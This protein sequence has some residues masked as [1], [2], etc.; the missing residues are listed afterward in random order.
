MRHSK[1]TCAS[2]MLTSCAYILGV[3]K[4]WWTDTNETH[5]LVGSV[6]CGE[7]VYGSIESYDI[8]LYSFYLLE[9]EYVVVLNTCNSSY[10]TFL[11]LYDEYGYDVYNCDDCGSCHLRA[12]LTL[13]NLDAGLYYIGVGGFSSHSGDYSLNVSCGN[14]NSTSSGYSETLTSDVESS[15]PATLT[16]KWVTLPTYQPTYADSSNKRSSDIVS[17][18]GGI[19][20]MIIF[21]VTIIITCVL[22]VFFVGCIRRVMKKRVRIHNCNH[23]N[24]DVI[25]SI[26][27]IPS[28]APQN[29]IAHASNIVICNIQKEDRHDTQEIEFNELNSTQL[30]QVAQ[31][32]VDTIV[33]ADDLELQLGGSDT[34]IEDDYVGTTDPESIL[35]TSYDVKNTNANTNANSIGEEFEEEEEEEDWRHWKEKDVYRWMKLKLMRNDLDSET[36]E[37][38]M[39]KVFSKM[40]M[41]GKLLEKLKTDERFW[42]DFEKQIK[43]YS[44]G[45]WMVVGESIKQLK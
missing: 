45:I 8:N 7:T 15:T 42:S 40:H 12:I 10:D 11:Y 2:L 37:E 35:G 9:D 28:P 3:C 19:T 27:P 30:N 33:N 4:G 14:D 20:N 17:K 43:N 22:I 5:T 38:F 34:D 44:F 32:T 25:N 41:T 29:P 1:D 6:D 21:T 18:V 36:I 31:L 39:N 26:Q 13:Y 24:E 16:T 23:D